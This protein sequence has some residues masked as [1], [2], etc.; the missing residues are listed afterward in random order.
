MKIL[1]IDIETFSSVDIG[2]AGLYKYVQS[3]DFEI[4]LFGYSFDYGPAKRFYIKG[5]DEF[6]NL[7]FACK[8]VTPDGLCS[9]YK[10]R[11]R[12]CRRYPAKRISYPGKLHDGCGYKVNIKKFDD[13]LK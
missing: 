5:K 13:Y 3:D 10:H 11:P 12:M 6:G 1:S 8:M 9:D 4:L 2:S 7:V